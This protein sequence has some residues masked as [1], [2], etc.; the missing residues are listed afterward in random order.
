MPED[1]SSRPPEDRKPGA[2]NNEVALE[3]M[4]FIAVTTGYGKGATSAA[5]F[6]GKATKTPEEYAEALLGLFDKCR[7]VV[8]KG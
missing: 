8:A 2:T 4:K 6:S 7:E 5:G 3:M 1:V